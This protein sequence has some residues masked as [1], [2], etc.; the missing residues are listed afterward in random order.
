MLLL[1]QQMK[2]KAEEAKPEGQGKS[3]ATS[4]TSAR[5]TRAKDRVARER[6][7]PCFQ[8]TIEKVMP[9]DLWGW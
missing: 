6:G 9:V 1:W 8:G 5:R 3:L 7:K 4:R 2:D